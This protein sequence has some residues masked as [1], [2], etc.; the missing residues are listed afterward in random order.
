MIEMRNDRTGA[1][2]SVPHV[3]FSWTTLFFGPLVP[4]FRGDWKWALIM[5]F[6]SHFAV[7]AAALASN[8]IARMSTTGPL[9]PI[10]PVVVGVGIGLLVTQPVFAAIYNRRYYA[11]LLNDGFEESSPDVDRGG[12]G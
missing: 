10:W 11:D 7:A 9:A 5:Y 2:R 1:R 12:S 8:A 4:L 6:V 3:G